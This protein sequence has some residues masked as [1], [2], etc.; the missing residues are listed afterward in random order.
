[1]SDVIVHVRTIDDAIAINMFN[2]GNTLFATFASGSVLDQRANWM[3]TYDDAG[4]R[5]VHVYKNGVE[6]AYLRQ[7]P[8][9]GTFR[10]TTNPW[11][12]GNQESGIRGLEGT[13]DAVRIYDVALAPGEIAALSALCPP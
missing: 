2:T 1:V 12:I 3:V 5:R 8:V 9:A 7:D 13:I 10:T 6:A 11:R 4:D